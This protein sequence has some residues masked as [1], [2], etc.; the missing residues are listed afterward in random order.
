MIHVTVD[1]IPGGF[2]PAR[3]TIGT[4]RIANVSD[5]ADISDYA[6]DFLQAA[7]PLTDS[8]PC[9]G[10]CEVRGHDRRQSI[11]ALLARAAE[12]AMNAE[13]DEL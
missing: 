1:L 5:L 12:A 6:V 4:L 8:K 7:N 13:F 9:N 11:W 10:S 2:A 3:R